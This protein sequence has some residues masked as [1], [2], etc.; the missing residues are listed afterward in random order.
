[1]RGE[2]PKRLACADALCMIEKA[3]CRVGDK[4]HALRMY[5]EFG[6]RETDSKNCLLPIRAISCCEKRAQSAELHRAMGTEPCSS[7]ARTLHSDGVRSPL[8]ARTFLSDG[9]IRR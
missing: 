4:G 2:P 3:T 8:S 5:I 9:N 6:A 7:P 1:M